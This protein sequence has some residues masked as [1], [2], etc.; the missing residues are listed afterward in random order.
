VTGDFELMDNQ[1]KKGISR[2][3]VRSKTTVKLETRVHKHFLNFKSDK[4][5]MRRRLNAVV[6]TGRITSDWAK[7]FDGIIDATFKTKTL[8]AMV[9]LQEVKEFE[10]NDQGLLQRVYTPVNR[11]YAV[12]ELNEAGDFPVKLTI[13]TPEAIFEI[14]KWDD[15]RGKLTQ[16]GKARKDGAPIAVGY[17]NRAKLDAR[18]T[19]KIIRNRLTEEY[20]GPA[21]PLIK[22][23]KQY[24]QDEIDKVKDRIGSSALIV[25]S[26]VFDLQDENK[27]LRD[28]I[29]DLEE[30]VRR[31]GDRDENIE[32]L[33][34]ETVMKLSGER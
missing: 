17:L 21:T 20:Y 2:W 14:T 25:Q 23:I 31:M 27:L 22:A 18:K 15:E 32:Q 5:L 16:A 34:R 28:R 11:Q 26:M 33:V 13:H 6:R 12:L 24:T 10:R 19:E 30:T 9:E 1:G 3:V 7:E 4:R 8:M 29:A